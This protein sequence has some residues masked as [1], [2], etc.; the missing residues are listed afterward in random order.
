M[1]RPIYTKGVYRSSTRAE[2]IREP[3]DIRDK[4]LDSSRNGPHKDKSRSE[5][6]RVPR[7]LRAVRRKDIQMLSSRIILSFN[8]F[9]VPP[10]LYDS[11]F[12]S[13]IFAKT[14]DGEGREKVGQKLEPRNS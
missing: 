10:L 6:S 4:I 14:K 2:R 8:K 11:F 12:R 9:L 3:L 13:L 5:T 7:Y 1:L